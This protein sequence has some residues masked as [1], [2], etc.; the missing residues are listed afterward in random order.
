M[1]STSPP[2]TWAPWKTLFWSPSSSSKLVH[3]TK[4]KY[5]PG[6]RCSDRHT[7]FLLAV[8]STC[9][10]VVSRRRPSFVHHHHLVPSI[11]FFFALALYPFTIPS[12]P[13]PRVH[14]LL[15]WLYWTSL[16]L[17]TLVYSIYTLSLSLI[18]SLTATRSPMRCILKH[19]IPSA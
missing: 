9:I 19:S 16:L 10:H 13:F 2:P 3:E 12:G 6:G 17:S 7:A 11:L 18:P 15:F 5:P 14:R 4:S 1:S 8:T